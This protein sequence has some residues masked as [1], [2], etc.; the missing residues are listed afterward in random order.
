MNILINIYKWLEKTSI[1]TF[2]TSTPKRLLFLIYRIKISF[3]K[4]P[5]DLKV[6]VQ[7]Y[8]KRDA[9]YASRLW[10]HL[11]VAHLKRVSNAYRTQD[12]FSS[13]MDSISK[14]YTLRFNTSEQLKEIQDLFLVEKNQAATSLMRYQEISRLMTNLLN[15]SYS[16]S[17]KNELL[18]VH[19]P[20]DQIQALIELDYIGE[21]V[22][23]DEI[24]CII[25]V[26]AGYGRIPAQLLSL[27]KLKRYI[28]VDIP[29]ALWISSV[30]LEKKFPNIK[31]SKYCSSLNQEKLNELLDHN[32]VIFLSPSQ[33]VYLPSD[34]SAL[35]LAI[36]CLQ[37][38]PPGTIQQYFECFSRVAKY[39]YIKAQKKPHDPWSDSFLC[40]EQY[41]LSDIWK[42]KHQRQAPFPACYSEVLLTVLGHVR[43]RVWAI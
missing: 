16:S 32:Q 29:P 22:N 18:K 24:S 40:F 43:M 5:S 28:I 4:L 15:D 33:M 11:M 23:M 39:F 31:I 13:I 6:M 41:I 38:M 1:T 34:L 26:G 19:Y 25:E 30:Y 21:H 35:V 9:K 17:Q 42:V 12:F 3:L 2:K 8:F 27:G 37:E 36:N 7:D 10:I 14:N 20:Q